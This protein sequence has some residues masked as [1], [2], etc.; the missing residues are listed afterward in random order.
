M[1]NDLFL[2]SW[3]TYLASDLMCTDQIVMDFKA[4]KINAT[5]TFFANWYTWAANKIFQKS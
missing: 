3:V 4:T 1:S 5:N 2:G